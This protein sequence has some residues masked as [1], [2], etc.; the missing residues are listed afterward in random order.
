MPF[1]D[2]ALDISRAIQEDR[3]LDSLK[4][5]HLGLRDTSSPSQA[6]FIHKGI[7]RQSSNFPTFLRSS[8]SCLSYP[9]P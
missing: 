1:L 3:E 8:I 2:K 9:R 7:I 4:A 5:K 6:L